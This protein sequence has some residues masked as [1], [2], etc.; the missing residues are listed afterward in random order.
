V[1]TSQ[2]GCAILSLS[3]SRVTMNP[4]PPI[5][6]YGSPQSPTVL[7]LEEWD[8]GARVI[9]PAMPQWAYVL[10]ILGPLLP[11]LGNLGLA[12]ACIVI[13]RR[14]FRGSILTTAAIL[15][16]A[17]ISWGLQSLGWGS[18]FGFHLW[19]YKRWGRV[20]RILTAD[21]QGLTLSR[22]GWR[23]M[24]GKKW[25]ASQIT[26][27]ELRPAIGNLFRSRTVMDVYVRRVKGWRLLFRLSS[28]DPQLPH[29]IAQRMSVIL[30]CPLKN[31]GPATAPTACLAKADPHRG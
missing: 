24:S 9:F 17:I 12:V 13:F 11:A 25:A 29:R 21:N 5:L 4:A 3:V 28:T 20:P 30:G 7:T 14:F 2:H 22:L 19:K 27:I 31:S 15:R 10:A 26:D 6:N 16:P 8:G 23:R 1:L 18:L